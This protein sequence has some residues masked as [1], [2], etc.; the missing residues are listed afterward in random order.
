MAHPYVMV[1]AADERS[2]EMRDKEM[3]GKRREGE[4]FSL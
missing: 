3:R 2:K 1:H 4:T